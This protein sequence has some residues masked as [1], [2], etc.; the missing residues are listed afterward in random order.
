MKKVAHVT[1]E[2]GTL[3]DAVTSHLNHPLGRWMFGQTGEADAARF[4]L[5]EEQDVVGGETSPGEHFDGEEVG[6]CQDG[7][8]GGDEILPGGILAPLGCRLDPVAAKDVAHCLIGNGVAEIGQGSDDAVVSPA[9]VFSGE[10]HNE[11]FQFRRDAG[12]ARSGAEFGAVKFAG[13]EP[14]VPGEDGIGFGDTGDLLKCS[15][16]EPFANF[17][18]GRSPGIRK[19]HTGGKVGSEDAILGCKVFVLEQ[20][21]LIDQPGDIRQQ[22][23]PFVVWHEEHPSETASAQV[24]IL[25]TRGCAAEPFS[26][27]NVPYCDFERRVE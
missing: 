5:N 7:H 11:G 20:E 1:E 6:T 15:P 2:S 3:V 13:N 22:P 9:G 18:E 14:A 23:S 21:F 26:S 4:Q 16:A 25:T 24:N 10:A 17:S 27:R 19:A 12:P 8:V